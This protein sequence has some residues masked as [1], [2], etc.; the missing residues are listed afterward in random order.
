MYEVAGGEGA[1]PYTDRCDAPPTGPH[2]VQLQFKLSDNNVVVLVMSA[3]NAVE[4]HKAIRE[5][6]ARGHLDVFFMV[7]DRSCDIPPSYRTTAF[8]YEAK[9]AVS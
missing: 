5:T 1:R 2:P 9:G 4:R 3:R 8:S 7:E 6:W